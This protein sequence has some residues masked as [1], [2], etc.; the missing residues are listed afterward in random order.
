MTI[1][2]YQYFMLPILKYL[3][4]QEVHSIK[5]IRKHIIEKG[6]FT[7]EEKKTVTSSGNLLLNDRISWANTYIHNAGLIKRIKRGHYQI[8][9]DGLELLKENH[10]TITDN[11]LKRYE[12]FR[13]YLSKSNKTNKNK[14]ENY[15]LEDT[16]DF[17]IKTIEKKTPLENIETNY[18]LIQND[19]SQKLLENIFNSSPEFFERLVVD[20]LIAM[21]YGGSRV[22]AGKAIGKTNDE[23]IDEIGRAHV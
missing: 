18:N 1:P 16:V 19:V 20:L 8:T 14:K 11:T 23:G 13:N 7:E 17:P 12:S 22:D 2:N 15:N 21:G 5:E 9:E 4:N 3:Q 10:E 6:D